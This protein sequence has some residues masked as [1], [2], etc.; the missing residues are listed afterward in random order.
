MRERQR[1]DHGFTEYTVVR[2]EA[3]FRSGWWMSGSDLRIF[4]SVSI[5]ENLNPN[6]ALQIYPYIQCG[7]VYRKSCH[8]YSK[9]RVVITGATGLV[10]SAVVRQ[11][12][13]NQAITEACSSAPMHSQSGDY[14]GPDSDA[15]TITKGHLW[16]PQNHRYHSR[17]FRKLSTR[18]FNTAQRC[19]GLYMVC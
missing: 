13:A 7:G 14:R 19:R 1:V 6:Y 11:C 5:P 10:G 9:M 17:R 16:Q 4:R 3:V 2:K 18:T 15:K 8:Q 12:I